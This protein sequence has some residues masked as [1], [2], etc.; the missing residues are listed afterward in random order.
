MLTESAADELR[1][2]HYRALK[3]AQQYEA[4]TPGTRSKAAKERALDRA[5]RE[6]ANRLAF[7]TD[8]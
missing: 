1:V 4:A 5:E 8:K 7:Y 3:A 2:L 6:Y